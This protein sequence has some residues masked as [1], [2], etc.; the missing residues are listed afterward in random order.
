MGISD[1]SPSPTSASRQVLVLLYNCLGSCPL[2]YG[3]CTILFWRHRRTFLSWRLR[4]SRHAWLRA[5]HQSMVYKERARNAHGHMVQLQ[6]ICTDIRRTSSLRHRH[7]SSSPW[8]SYRTLADCVSCHRPTYV[9]HWL[10]IPF[11]RARQ[12]AQCALAVENRPPPCC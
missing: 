11:L 1:Q 7:R 5:I 10:H 9:R 2:L 12:S 6:R 4:S 3:R 8:L